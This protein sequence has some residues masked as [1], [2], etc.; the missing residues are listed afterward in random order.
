LKGSSYDTVS[1]RHMLM[2]SSGVRWNEDYEDPKSDAAKYKEIDDDAKRDIIDYM[3][4]L[5][6]ESEPG[7]KFLYRTGDSNMLG[8]L[9]AKATGKSMAQY[10]SEKIWAPYGMEGEAIWLTSKGFAQGGSGLSMRLRDFG[11]FGQF[12]M[13]GGVVNGKSILPDGWRDEATAVHLPTGWGDVGYG[14]QW[15]TRADGTYRALGIFGQLIFTDPKKKLIV[16]ALSAWPRADANEFYV[17]EDA[18]LSAVQ[19]AVE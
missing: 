3:A 11:R 2:M 8:I 17:I 5:P 7:A 19:K 13:D 4:S 12:F 18:Y 9:V 15:W 10:L 14:Y 1:I 6:R 16:V